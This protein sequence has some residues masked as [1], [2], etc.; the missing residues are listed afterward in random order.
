MRRAATLAAVCLLLFTGCAG[1]P[2]TPAAAP[3]TQAAVG[4]VMGAP[5]A[6]L[7]PTPTPEPT[8]A[9]DPWT[10]EEVEAI[11]RTLSGECYEDKP[12]DKRLVAEVILNRVT[13]GRWGDT[14]V[15]VV[16]AKSQFFGYWNP[17]RDISDNDRE[18]AA[19][20]LRDWY[21]NDCTALSE[22]LFF[23]AGPNREN[24]FREKY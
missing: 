22:Y 4:L 17:S 24:V 10:A 20:A 2:A 18:I 11:A 23:E 19:Q 5:A 12:G 13:D 1:E 9:P 6:T 14:V 8:P 7:T 16:T 21:T 3:A 15:E